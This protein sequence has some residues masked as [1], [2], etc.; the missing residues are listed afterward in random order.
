MKG[1]TEEALRVLG[2]QTLALFRPGLLLG[3]RAR[4]RFGERFFGTLL[5][6]ADPLM[7]GP[8]RK[9]RAIPG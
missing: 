6:V 9:Y 7:F 3:E 8:L 2:F 5:W 1:E 4:P